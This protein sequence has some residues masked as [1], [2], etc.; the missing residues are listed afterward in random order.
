[1][2]VFLK[3]H[4]NTWVLCS[5]KYKNISILIFV[6]QKYLNTCQQNYNL[7]FYIYELWSMFL[8]ISIFYMLVSL[9]CN[10]FMESGKYFYNI[11]YCILLWY[12]HVGM[13]SACCY[14]VATFY[15][16]CIFIIKITLLIIL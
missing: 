7:K 5:L 15:F 11:L 3:I 4:F 8:C 12:N 2:I 9:V 13:L 14:I 16:K 6:L 1:M 10:L